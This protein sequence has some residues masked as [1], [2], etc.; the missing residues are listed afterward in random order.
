MSW[1][2]PKYALRKGWGHTVS[3][4][5]PY[6]EHAELGTVVD[7]ES[8]DAIIKWTTE[9]ANGIRISYDIWQFKTQQDAEEFIMLFTLRYGR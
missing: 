2:V 4:K 9:N 6:H 5:D 1:L 7:A 8:V 3:L